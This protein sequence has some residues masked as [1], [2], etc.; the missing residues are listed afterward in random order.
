MSASADPKSTNLNLQVT[1]APHVNN[2]F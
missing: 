2:R 1:I